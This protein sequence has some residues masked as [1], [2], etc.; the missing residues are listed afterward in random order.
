ML[1]VKEKK[2]N[3]MKAK[4]NWFE[5]GLLSV[6]V[7]AIICCFIFSSDKDYLSLASSILG[8]V[9]VVFTSKGLLLA[10]ILSVVYSIVYT[11]ISVGQRYYGEAII[12]MLI[13]IPMQVITIV[14]WFRNKKTDSDVVEVGKVSKKEYLILSGV[15]VVMTFAF[16][17]LLKV[18]NTAQLVVST[19]S[20]ITSA[21]ATYLVFRRSSNYALFYILNDIILIVLWTIAL[22]AQ[23]TSLLPVVVSFYV[24]F[25]NDVYGFIRWKRQEKLQVKEV[26]T[27]TN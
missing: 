8:V 1:S 7:V 9:T 15:T 10:P 3:V 22:V 27:E 13:M 24:F 25:I 23:G 20:L 16:Y 19:I 4:W 12:Y 11:I 14:G 5:I 18:L 21:L 6:S 2:E 26:E 17:F